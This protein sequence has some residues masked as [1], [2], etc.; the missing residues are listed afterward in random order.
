MNDLM[1]DPTLTAGGG[2]G[3]RFNP[4]VSGGLDAGWQARASTFEMPP[5]P[6]PGQA[7][8]ERIELEVWWMSGPQRRT[9]T[10]EAFREHLL[11]AG[12]M[13]AGAQR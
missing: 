1:L 9:F 7:A 13:P 10:L 11:T 4:A 8:L 6:A 3:G 5:N 12:N 2:L